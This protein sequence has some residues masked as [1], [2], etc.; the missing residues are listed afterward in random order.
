AAGTRPGDAELPVA[1]VQDR[2][3]ARFQVDRCQGSVVPRVLAWTLGDDGG[4]AAGAAP[5]RLPHLEALPGD[6]PDLARADL[7]G[8]R[9]SPAVVIRPG[10][11]LGHPARGVFFRVSGRAGA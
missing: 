4:Q 9:P 7:V 2:L 5:G 3:L 6:R 11:D 1:P 10:L 8:P